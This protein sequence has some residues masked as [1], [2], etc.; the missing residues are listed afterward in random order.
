MTVTITAITTTTTTAT[1]TTATTAK[2][3]T[4]TTTTTTTM[5]D[6]FENSWRCCAWEQTLSHFRSVRCLWWCVVLFWSTPAARQKHTKRLTSINV[7]LLLLLKTERIMQTLEN[8]WDWNQSACRLGGTDYDGLDVLN[9]KMQV[10]SVFPCIPWK[11]L[12]FF[13]LYSRPSKYL[14]TGLVLEGP[15]IWVSKSLKVLEFS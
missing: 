12:N 13:P 11:S 5:C 15:W 1:T 7:L 6:M 10:T 4:A 9:M 2:T 14:K 3:T 8:C